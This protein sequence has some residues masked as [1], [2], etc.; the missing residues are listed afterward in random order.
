MSVKTR[1]ILLIA[2]LL[3][4]VV[5]SYAMVV[6]SLGYQYDFSEN[7]I[8]RT[9]SFRIISNAGADVYWNGKFDGSTS[10]LSHSFI[11]GHIL[12]GDYTLE[13]KKNG[14]RSYKKTANVRAG[15]FTD[16]PKTILLKEE[17]PSVVVASSSFSIVSA[18]FDYDT[19]IVK[20]A[21]ESFSKN[22]TITSSEQTIVAKDRLL[23][24][25]GNE[26]WIQWLSDTDYQPFHTVNDL[27]IILKTRSPITKAEWYKDRNHIIFS[28][29]GI[30]WF[31]EIDVRGGLNVY[32]ISPITGQFWYEK[33]DDAVY[34]VDG[35]AIKRLQF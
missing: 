20:I 4:F 34:V 35:K 26:I 21:S 7:S 19:N 31:S 13:M 29:G 24:I 16:F 32:A 14:F 3:I 10:F 6:Y 28:E 27:E 17:I 9:G 15:F 8:V 22:K 30:L 25:H 11:K 12:P 2:S 5:A 18:S 1:W 33:N 23:L